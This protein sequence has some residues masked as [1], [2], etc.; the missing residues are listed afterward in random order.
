MKL[1]AFVRLL[2]TFA[3]PALSEPWD[4]TGLLLEP[5]REA[6]I[7]KVLLT[8]DLT[9]SVAREA[10]AARVDAVVAYH[11]PLFHAVKRLTHKHPMQ[12][13]LLDLATAGI[14]VY[15]PHTAL[16]A[17]PGGV[18][19]WLASLAGEGALEPIPRLGEDGVLRPGSGRRN[20]LAEEV[21]VTGIVE[22]MAGALGTDYLRV[23]LAVGG[24]MQ[25][26]SV[27][28]C[29][30]SGASALRGAEA[31]VWITGEMSHHDVLAAT[32]AGVH[33]ILSE[34]TRTERGYLPVLKERMESAAGRGLRVMVSKADR[35]PLTLVPTR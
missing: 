14:A 10:R 35:C 31:D 3:P 24:P 20:M 32:A 34:H 12:S 8:I 9:A 27:A 4:N 16:D 2:E 15:S 33:V 28:V 25:I 13:A 22:R 23:A 17:A 18:N 11:P 29:A 7:R 30:G 1:P 19:D 21:P 6:D 26:R 5:R